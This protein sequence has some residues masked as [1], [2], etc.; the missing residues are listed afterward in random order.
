MDSSS[1]AIYI[2]IAAAQNSGLSLINFGIGGIIR[3]AMVLSLSSLWNGG[4]FRP[5]SAKASLKASA[6]LLGEM[7][8]LGGQVFSPNQDSSSEEIKGVQS[9]KVQDYGFSFVAA[10]VAFVLAFLY[11]IQ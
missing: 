8:C 4:N 6:R 5:D 10:V 1:C 3:Y 2:L 11:F 7:Y 9:G